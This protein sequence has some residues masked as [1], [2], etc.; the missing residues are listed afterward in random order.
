MD[1]PVKNPGDTG[2]VVIGRNEGER[3]KRCLRSLPPGMAA[4]YVDS[5]S[6]D[7]SVPFASS[8]GVH[9]VELDMRLPFTAAR[10]RN[11]GWQTI[12]AHNSELEFVQFVDGDCEVAADWLP[13]AREALIREQQT[14]AVFGRRRERFPDR[15]IY[16]KMCD[17]EW[18]APIGIVDSCGGDALLRLHALKEAQGYNDALIAGEEPDLCLRL[19]QSG[20]TIRCIDHEMTVHDA[21]ITSFGTF[22]RRTKRSGFAFAEHVWRHGRKGIPSWQRQLIGIVLWGLLLPLAGLVCLVLYVSVGMKAG[23]ALSVAC[24][25][26]YPIQMTRVALRKNEEVNDPDFAAAYGVLTVIGKFAQALG[27]LQCWGV[28]F[29]GRRPQLIEYKRS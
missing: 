7:G 22:W 19:R 24:L 21:A 25:L 18:A 13:A 9:V 29:R 2:I 8:M 27:T 1:A 12:E 4:V 17:D 28:K 15:S 3:L 11:I 6:T 10:A 14:A 26:A 16:N 23:L 5:G 20:W